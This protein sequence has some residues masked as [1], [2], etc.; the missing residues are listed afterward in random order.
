MKKFK[1]GEYLIV[2]YPYWE[3]GSDGLVQVFKESFK[4]CFDLLF[5]IAEKSAVEGDPTNRPQVYF[6]KTMKEFEYDLEKLNYLY[7]EVYDE[8]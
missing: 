3:K 4:K 1:S 2:I 7:N 5:F 8:Q 6:L